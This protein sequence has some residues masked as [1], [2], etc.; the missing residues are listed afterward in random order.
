LQDNDARYLLVSW[1][2][3]KGIPE[4]AKLGI[5]CSATETAESH[6]RFMNRANYERT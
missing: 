2:T 5:V 4:G 6:G 3:E 1:N